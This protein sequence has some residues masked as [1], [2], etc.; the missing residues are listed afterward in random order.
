MTGDED[1]PARSGANASGKFF[2]H[3]GCSFQRAQAQRGG[4][5]QVRAMTLEFES[6]LGVINTPHGESIGLA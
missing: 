4:H 6:Y 5:I 1:L 3:V 2:W